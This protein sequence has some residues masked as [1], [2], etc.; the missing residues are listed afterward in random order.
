LYFTDPDGHLLEVHSG[1]LVTRLK[2]YNNPSAL[3]G[4]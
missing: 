1:D 2:A 4:T 3:F